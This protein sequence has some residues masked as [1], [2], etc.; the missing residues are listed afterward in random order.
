MKLPLDANQSRL[1]VPV[2]LLQPDS[3]GSNQVGAAG[4]GIGV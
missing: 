4:Q 3:S 1:T 2:P